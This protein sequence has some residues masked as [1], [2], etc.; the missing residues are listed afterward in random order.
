[1]IENA[2][3][4]KADLFPTDPIDRLMG[5][6]QRFLRVETTSGVVLIVAT[7]AALLWAN[8]AAGTYSSFWNTSLDL[9]FGPWSLSGSLD[10]QPT[11]LW[12]VN[13]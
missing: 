11:L 6:I 12:L 5:P 8:L 2:E 4:N 10:H 9:S 13:D 1:M 7:L 3:P